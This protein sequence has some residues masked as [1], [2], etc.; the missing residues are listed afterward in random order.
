MKE[1]LKDGRLE[2]ALETI[3]VEYE[4]LLKYLKEK[5]DEI[6][7]IFAREIVAKEI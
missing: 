5:I 6:K 2:K 4:E 7:K 3:F 1:A